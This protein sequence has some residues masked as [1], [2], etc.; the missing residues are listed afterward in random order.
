M[1]GDAGF[2]MGAG[3]IVQ[4]MNILAY[5]V[6]TRFYSAADFGVFAAVLAMA[7]VIGSAI[8]LRLDMVF[9]L[10]SKADENDLLRSAFAISLTLAGAVFCLIVLGSGSVLP[11]VAGTY[12]DQM[13][14]LGWAAMIAGMG[15]LIGWSALGRQI[16]SKS[17]QYRRLSLAQILRAMVAI[18]MQYAAVLIWPSPFGLLFGFALGLLVFNGLT[19]ILPDQGDQTALRPTVSSTL[20]RHK[21]LIRVD[22][23]N[24]MISALV[25]S[26]YPVV[27]LSVF[28]ETSAG[29]FA[30]ASRFSFIP[31]EFLGAAISTVFFQ[32]F[33]ESIRSNAGSLQLF[34]GTLGVGLIAGLCVGFMFW[35]GADWFVALLFEPEWAPTSA[36]IL[37]LIPT[38][39]VRFY[40]GCIGSAP[41][42]MKRPGLLFIWNIAQIVIVGGCVG[43]TRIYGLSLRDFLLTSGLILLVA[44]VIYIGFVAAL[45]HQ[46]VRAKGDAHAV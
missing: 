36:L 38:M 35:V 19:L 10:I 9:Q 1:M 13:P 15:L 29:Y 14:I 37:A 2:L 24:V 16:R 28:G 22:T 44:S 33:S 23:V 7:T 18:G 45:L 21:S 40:M 26:V 31:V 25:L 17:V 39:V 20:K 34:W 32:R 3:V 6:L 42:A 41:L 5:P 30:I 46:S 8:C 11:W 43:V 12:L 4:V 27:I